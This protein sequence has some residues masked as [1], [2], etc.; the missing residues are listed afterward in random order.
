MANTRESFNYEVCLCQSSCF[1][2]AANIDLTCKW[3]SERLCTKDLL[4]N[5]VDDWVVNS[6]RK[7]HGKLWRHNIRNNEHATQHNLVSRSVRIQQSY[8]QY[9]VWR[10]QSKHKQNQQVKVNLRWFN[11]HAILTKQDNT[12]QLSLFG[13]KTILQYVAYNSTI[14]NCMCWWLWE[15]WNF[16]HNIIGRCKLQ[17]ISPR[18]QQVIPVSITSLQS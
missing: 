13:L 1:V 17:N 4:L 18:M 6:D 7:L 3:N 2:E 8:S 12:H 14:L 5:Q 9:V 16:L 10:N 15:L 11:T